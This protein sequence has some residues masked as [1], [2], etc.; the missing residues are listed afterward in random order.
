VLD[1]D[2]TV[3]LCYPRARV[4]DEHGNVRHDYNVKL[5]TDAPRAHDRYR[6]LIWVLNR[7]YEVFGLMRASTL[8]KTSW[9]GNYAVADRVLLAELGLRG[10][11][12]EIREYLFFP[13]SHAGK[14][15]QT[16]KE[17]TA[18]AVW[19]DPRNEGRI[20]MPRWRVGIGY[21]LPLGRTPMSWNERF[22]CGIQI[23][24]WFIGN[25]ERLIGDLTSAG[26]QVLRRSSL[27]DR[28]VVAAKR[29]QSAQ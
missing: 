22:N 9:M 15:T 29:T 2:P 14:F 24:G 27:I 12:H 13:R 21:L 8:K 28:L 10:R 17:R 19:F 7:C 18:Q 4:I 20:I 16:C 25:R 23:A 26:K 1:R 5:N 6:D 3:V 11:F